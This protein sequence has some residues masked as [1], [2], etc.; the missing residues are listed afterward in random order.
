MFL[1][2]IMSQTNTILIVEDELG[3]REA[4]RLIL[5]PFY[6][7]Y[8]AS[9]GEDA[10][11]IVQTQNIDVMTLDLNMPGLSG[12]DVLREIKKIKADLEV[13]VITALSAMPNAQKAIRYGA[14][15]FLSKPF[16]VR[17]VLSTI[18]K[19]IERLHYNSKIHKLIPKPD[20]LQADGNKLEK[21]SIS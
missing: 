9:N 15:D 8:I 16:H 11:K 2:E 14:S 10:I 5:K 18:R 1:E 13:I 6:K 7:L 4:I 12:F 20:D 21:D 17:D 3:P 19:S